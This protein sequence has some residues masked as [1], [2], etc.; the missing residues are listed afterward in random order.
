MCRNIRVL[1][2]FEPPTT[3]DEIRAAALQ[4]VRKVSGLAKPAEG[5]RAVFEAAIDAISETTERLVTRL[6]ARAPVR[7]RQ[8]EIDKAKTRWKIREA[9]MR[10]KWD[11]ETLERFS[12]LLGEKVPELLDRESPA[13][14]AVDTRAAIGLLAWPGGRGTAEFARTAALHAN[15]RYLERPIAVTLAVILH[16]AMLGTTRPQAQ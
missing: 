8:G 14:F 11:G 12:I 1:Y 10:A 13:L 2:N 4:Y 3:R 15:A 7:T 9:R 16:S 5:D 6:T